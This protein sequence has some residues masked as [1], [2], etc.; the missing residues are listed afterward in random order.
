MI[1]V[2]LNIKKIKIIIFNL[3]KLLLVFAISIENDDYH[4]KLLNCGQALGFV[5]WI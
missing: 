2:S 1:T 4:N 3:I 5:S